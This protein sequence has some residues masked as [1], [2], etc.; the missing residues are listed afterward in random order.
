MACRAVPRPARV[1]PSFSVP[2]G[3][4]AVRCS[5]CQ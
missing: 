2:V 5:A 1:S 3:S 4:T